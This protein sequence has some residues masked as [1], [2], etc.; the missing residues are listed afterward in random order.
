MILNGKIVADS[1]KQKLKEEI[2]DAVASGRRRPHLVIVSVGDD[3]ASKVYVRNKMKAAEEVGIIANHFP[4]GVIEDGV[5]STK[6][7]QGIIAKLNVDDEVDGIMVQLPLPKYLDERAIIDAI[8]PSKDVDG[9]TTTNIGKLRSGQPCFQPCTAHGVIDL[10]DYYGIEIDSKDVTIVGRSNIVGK[11]LADLMM[12][13]GATVTQCHSRTKHLEDH[14]SYANIVVSAVGKPKFLKYD[15]FGSFQVIVDVG[16]NR[17]EN[18]KLCGDVDFDDVKDYCSAITP[19][20]GGV[21]PMTVAELLRNT[22]EAWK[23]NVEE[24]K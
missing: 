22:V 20:P 18:G 5:P 10:L 1:I 13:R 15:D 9:L 12:A 3:P 17:D 19:V 23:K 6:Y 4:M 8:D 2:D 16:I 7:V 14:T 24:N 11:P 21:G